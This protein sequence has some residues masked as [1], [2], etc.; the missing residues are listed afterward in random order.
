MGSRD[1]C[2]GTGPRSAARVRPRHV[3]STSLDGVASLRQRRQS[4]RAW[5]PHSWSNGLGFV[6]NL[7]AAVAFST[8]P[9][10]EVPYDPPAWSPERRD[11]LLGEPLEIASDGTIAPPPGPGLGVELD[12]ERLEHYRVG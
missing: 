5:S 6:A 2:G 7:H 4:N 9:F 8:V 12:F 10:V 11:W 3:R 1:S